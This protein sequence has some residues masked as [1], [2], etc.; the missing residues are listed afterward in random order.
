M[1]YIYKGKYKIIDNLITACDYYFV[2][3]EVDKAIK[4]KKRLLISPIASHT[5]VRAH[6][7]KSLKK[8]LDKFNYL[9]PDSQWVRWS[10]PF[11]YGKEKS[12]KDR[13]Y[14]PE[15]MLRV[16][17]LSVKK[18]YRV[19]LYGNTQAVLIK[20]KE[21]L[22][23][24]FLNLKLVGEEE[25]KFRDL[26]EKEWKNLVKN[27]KNSKANIVFIALGSPKQ[28][29]FAYELLKK[30][31]K[32]FVIIPI[33]AA[34]D[35]ISGNK[36]QAPKWMQKIGLEWLFRLSKEPGRLLT[37]YIFY[38]IMFVFSVLWQKIRSFSYKE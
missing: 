35:F 9:V 6:Y 23:G 2:L 33:G 31:K 14:G 13:V 36:L 37:R 4:N 20:L 22:K 38:G 29:V 28:E 26:R 16:L 27:I 12:L 3:S 21:K 18:N 11:L 1:V 7:D 34:F 8:I 15:L 17:N 24:R 25:S 30:L 19:F 5:L 32:P 10:I